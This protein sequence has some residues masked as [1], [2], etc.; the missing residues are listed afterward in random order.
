MHVAAIGLDLDRIQ[1]VHRGAAGAQ[2]RKFLAQGLQ[3]AVH[4]AREI[5]EA[6][7]RHLRVPS[8]AARTIVTAWD[9]AA[10]NGE[11]LLAFHHSISPATPEDIGEA[12]MLGDGEDKN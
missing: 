11:S 4:A 6:R 7:I 12:I 10:L 5:I 2:A 9:G 8:V 3:R 1:E